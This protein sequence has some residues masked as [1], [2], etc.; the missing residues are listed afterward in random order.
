MSA[1][2]VLEFIGGLVSLGQAVLKAAGGD[3]VKAQESLESIRASYEVGKQTIDQK[4][5]EDFTRGR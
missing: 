2:A 3:P 4:A 1:L 5:V